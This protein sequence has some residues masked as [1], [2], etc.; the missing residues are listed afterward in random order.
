MPTIQSLA[1]EPLDVPLTEPFGIA[2]GVQPVAK[3]V[4]VRLVLSDGTRGIGEAAP[5]PAVSGETQEQSLAT[6]ASAHAVLVGEKAGRWRRVARLLRELARDAPAARCAVETALLDALCRRAKLSLW[7]FF[8]GAEPELV[9][10]ITIVTGDEAHA[11]AAAERAT[12]IGFETL[13][14]KVGAGDHDLDVARLRAIGHVAPRA[15]LILDAN[16]SLGA[17]QAIELVR[18]LGPVAKRVVLFE[19]PTAADD[20][21]GMRRVREEGGVKVAADESAKSATSVALLTRERA[22]DVVNVKLMKSGIAEALE[23]AAAARAAGLGLMVGGMVE[24]RLAM[25]VGACFAAGIGGFCEIDLDTPLF[26]EHSPFSGGMTEDGPRL[27][28]AD[29]VAGHGVELA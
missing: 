8:G 13:K 24:T 5:F 2:S 18:A 20:L 3:N 15:R 16:A 12:K 27:G 19:Q 29:I 14:V 28:L 1:A 17:D 6:L 23:Q 22:A 7:S 9:T 11:R 21:D 26:V 4:L 10:D 25:S